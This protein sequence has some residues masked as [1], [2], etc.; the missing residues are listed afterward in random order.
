VGRR[1]VEHHVQLTARIH[2]RH[3]LHKAEEVSGG[4]ARRPRGRLVARPKVLLCQEVLS[5]FD[6][7]Q[8]PRLRRAADQPTASQRRSRALS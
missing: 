3:Q 8:P 2:A 5:S 1:V 4:V 7:L 6:G